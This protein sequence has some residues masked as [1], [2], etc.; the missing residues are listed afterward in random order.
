MYIQNYNDAPELEVLRKHNFLLCIK[1]CAAKL[2]SA[3]EDMELGPITAN[4]TELLT[5]VEKLIVAMDINRGNLLENCKN[6]AYIKYKMTHALENERIT[7]QAIKHEYRSYMIECVILFDRL[8][9]LLGMLN[10]CYTAE[11]IS[12]TENEDHLLGFFNP[13]VNDFRN[14][15]IH[16]YY[17]SH[18]S[19]ENASR[20]EGEIHN[21]RFNGNQDTEAER[22]LLDELSKIIREHLIWFK[23]TEDEFSIF[24]DNFF[25][26]LENKLVVSNDLLL[27][28]IM[29]ENFRVKYQR[30]DSLRRQGRHIKAFNSN[31]SEY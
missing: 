26:L 8:S 9:N 3:R 5:P 21:K 7:I 18:F 28:Q 2:V 27:P 24:F 29:P 17:D 14:R 23:L 4:Q 11:N 31:N 12:F 19:W 30:K 25:S 16:E 13:L 1:D 6:R 20:L 10:D 22:K 15:N